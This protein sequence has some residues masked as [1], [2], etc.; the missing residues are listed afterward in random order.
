VEARRWLDRRF[1]KSA[2]V[3]RILGGLRAP[4]KANHACFL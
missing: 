2:A 3:K 1:L 4:F